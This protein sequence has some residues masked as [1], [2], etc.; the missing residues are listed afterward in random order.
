ME[1]KMNKNINKVGLAC[2]MAA[3]L[4]AGLVLAA[5]SAPRTVLAAPPVNV[6]PQV[7]EATADAEEIEFLVVL[8]EQADLDAAAALPEREARLRYVY[9]ALRETALRSQASLRAELDAAGVGYRPFYIVNMLAVRG[10]RDLVTRLA[11]HP[12][13]A[14]IAANPRVR[15][16]L[17]EP[18]PGG[19]RSLAPGAVEWNVTRVNADDVWALGYTGQGI[20]VAGQDTGYDWDHP[21]LMSQYR[22]YDGTAVTHD[23][24]WHDAIHAN[25][26][27]TSPGNPCGFDSLVPC[28]DDDH[29]THTM[30]IMVGD[31]GGGNRIGVTPGA[32]WIGCRNME[33][34]W[35]TPASYAECFEFF[36]APY[37]IGG[38]PFTD[39][40]PSLAPHVIN[41]SWTCPSSEGCDWTT[42]Q[43]VVENV[44]TAGIVVV[45][46]AGNSGPACG[47]V[48]DPPAIYDAAFTVGS[49][50]TYDII[51]SSSSRG[52]VAKDGSVWLKPD[53]VAP[54]LGV[55]S[56]V[57]GGGYSFM[58]GTSMAGPHVAGTVALLWSAAPGLVGDVGTTEWLI[59]ST[60]RPRTTSQGC[61][62]DGPDDVPNNVYGWGILDAL[63]AVQGILPGLEVTKE[64]HPDPVW[65]GERLTYTVHVTNTG[66]M[67]L[68]ATLTDTLPA[69]IL[70]GET[71][72][73]T[74]I[75]PGGT[76][77][78]TLAPIRPG[79]IWSRTVA[80][81]VETGY[82]GPLTNVVRAVPDTG[83]AAVYTETVLS[84]VPRL[85]VSKEA[86]LASV[87]P[88]SPLVYTISVTNVLDLALGP[89]V[90]TDAVPAGT[91]FAWASGNYAQAGGVVTWTAESLA[92]LGTLR[93]TLGVT[94]GDLAPGTPVVNAAYGVRAGGMVTP[95]MGVPVELRVSWRC[96]LPL[97]L[98][99]W[100]AGG[101]GGG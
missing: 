32:R 11:V 88:G 33:E 45:A 54:G 40:V 42:L 101:G 47:T 7:W 87:L 38:S 19:V 79:G 66:T 18:Q 96:F 55:R 64:G 60:A 94:V 71:E 8:A 84:L 22:G 91:T 15:Q 89:V 78:W 25:D 14:R 59:T 29:G 70:P 65:A 48:Q 68:Y 85:G 58:S 43:T 5:R 92:G 9:D 57:S 17:P 50:D 81:T 16:A 52:P 28:D 72:D 93:A 1:T 51:A 24:N 77:T 12:G 53:V 98:K 2:G 67:D 97:T 82:A 86:S 39:G 26:I 80:V 100:P 95:V 56:S 23:Y 36:L 69:H 3:L 6:A 4:V 34:R 27:H 44:R 90:L 74:A 73:G 76:L 20:V 83:A 30:G 49:T 31:D 21:A 13:V 63:A 62:G 41:N 35:G 61:G 10:D 46:S 75:W 37:P 99:N